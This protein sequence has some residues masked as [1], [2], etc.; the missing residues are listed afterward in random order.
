MSAWTP[1]LGRFSN[2]QSLD[3]RVQAQFQETRGL[4]YLREPK[5]DLVEAGGPALG[6]VGIKSAEQEL[7]PPS[8]PLLAQGQAQSL[9]YGTPP[10][11][12]PW[13]TEDML[14]LWDHAS[15]RIHSVWLAL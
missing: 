1:D 6:R 9:I 7:E 5:I 2:R 14:E 11:P 8:S 10:S 4:A 12:K 15:R 13:P 3:T